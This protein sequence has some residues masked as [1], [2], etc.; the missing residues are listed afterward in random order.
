MASRLQPKVFL[1]GRVALEIDGVVIGEGSFPGR[2]GRVLFAYLVAEQGRP[3]PREELAEALWGETPPASWDK[4]LTGIVTKVRSLLAHQGIDGAA[5]TG[6]FGCYRL[7]LPEGAWVDVVAAANA[8]DEAEMA[9]AAGDFAEASNAAALAA[10]LLRQPFLPGEGGTWVEEKRRE[11][12]DARERAL[13]VLADASLRSGDTREAVKWAQQ[14]IALSPFRDSGY[15]RLMEAHVAAGNRAEALRVYERCRRLLAEE[16]G[17]YPSPE[18]ESVYRRVLEAPPPAPLNVTEAGTDGRPPADD[19]CQADVA[20]AANASARAPRSRFLAGLVCAAITIA[21]A[22]VAATMLFARGDRGASAEVS[23]NAVGIF[24]ADT[25]RPTGEIPVGQSPSAATVGSG[26]IW[27][28]NADGHTVSRIDSAKHSL[29]QTI[30]V[31]AGPSGITTGAGAVWVTNSLDGTVSRIDPGTNVTVQTIDVGTEPLGIVYAAGSVWVAN[32]GDATITRIDPESGKPL[33]TLPVAATELA[34]GAGTLW[35]TERAAGRV[36][37]IDPTTGKPVAA[38]QVG[39]GPTGIAIGG[40]AAWVANSLDGTV[41]R[42]DVDTNSVRATVLTGNGPAAVA[43]DPRGVWVSDQFDGTLARLDPRTNEVA[44]RLSLGNPPRGLALSGGK[45]LVAV[46]QSGAGHRGGTLRVR[47]TDPVDSIDTAVAYAPTSWPILRMTNDGLVAYNHAGGLAGTQLVP[48]LAI[49]LPAPSD[50]GKT[51]SFKLRPNI[52]YSTGRLLKAS[53]FR[54]AL[55]RDFE[56]GKLYAP[57]F[58]GILG[59]ARCRKHPRH[60]DLSRG[61]VADDAG[62]RLTFHLVRPDAEFLYKLALDFAYATPAE[63][64]PREARTHPLPATGPYMIA[65]YRPKHTLRLVRN[66]YFHE[67]SKAAQPDGYPD[68]IVFRMG[69]S[70]ASAVDAVIHGRADAY[71]TSPVV[72][73]PS[74]NLLET[75]R[76]RYASQ[77]HSNP[78][79]HTTA[80]F[81]NTRVA[82]FNRRDARKA[83]NYAANRLEAVRIVG[84]PEAAEATCQ[85]LPAGFP[86]YQR[87]CPYGTQNLAKAR[88]LVARSGTRGMKV[89]FWANPYFESLTPYAVKLLRSIGYHVSTKTSAADSYYD[90]VGDSRTGAQ[91]G[92][93]DWISDYPAASAFINPLLGCASRIPRSK[94]NLN[95]AE[96]CDLDL[97]RQIAAAL[98]AQVTDPYAARG[99]WQ[100]VDRQIVD[101]A[102]WVPLVNPKTVDVLSERVGNYEYSPNGFG[103]PYDQLWVR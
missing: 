38:I 50:G 27:V 25:G 54:A 99:L 84:G 32:T 86:G 92:I 17:A 95:D 97:D 1:A 77:V 39:N 28:T 71:S 52:H 58:D 13:D 85:I 3:V 35:A 53:D 66:P 102:P 75:L 19:E 72:N 88:A 31:G 67:W 73:P 48:D 93:T 36:I 26:S 69:G 16:L 10:S 79:P 96:F 89:T 47:M 62:R 12:A 100:R 57:Y 60:C 81:L 30:R 23:A 46:R 90:V 55:E 76:L 20:S 98:T 42:I 61:I 34:F 94:Y 91:I 22:A 51:Y 18:T 15:R 49:A 4:A 40:G 37:R 24:N 21:T 7:E 63:T 74:S 5:L 59:A 101:E 45:V 11:L 64:A 83:L 41:S 33:K 2:Q 6:A 56:I 82:P 78:Q 44:Q 8:E 87:Y 43:V 65:S 68:E 29:V 9:L 80:L 103:T 70:A 14:A